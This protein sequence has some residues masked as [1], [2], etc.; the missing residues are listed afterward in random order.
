MKK[1]LLLL[2]IALLLMDLF[3]L[4]STRPLHSPDSKVQVCTF[5]GCGRDVVHEVTVVSGSTIRL[6]LPENEIV[7]QVLYD[8]KTLHAEIGP[9]EVIVKTKKENRSTLLTVLTGN[10]RAYV[11]RINLRAAKKGEKSPPS[12]QYIIIRR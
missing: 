12:E 3:P 2:F 11:F 10:N 6:S 7:K 4:R 1:V 8:Q 9:D 5:N